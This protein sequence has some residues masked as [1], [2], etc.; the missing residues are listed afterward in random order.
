M[1][2]KNEVLLLAGILLMAAL[3][4]GLLQY[5]DSNHT[6][7]TR[8]LVLQ[9]GVERMNLSAGDIGRYEI[10]NSQGA[11]N[12]LEISASGVRMVAANCP[13]QWCIKKG[14]VGP[15]ADYIACL[16]NRLLVRWDNNRPG[17][18]EIDVVVQ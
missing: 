5:R 1:F 16:P 6:G 15:G 3:A 7:A 2:K 12:V 17:D 4:Y 11:T 9:D 18:D 13:D 8:V 14:V 10:K